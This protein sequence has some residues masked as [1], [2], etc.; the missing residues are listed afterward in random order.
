MHPGP[1]EDTG[2]WVVIGNAV[3]AAREVQVLGLKDAV[4]SAV[5]AAGIGSAVAFARNR[6]Y[7]HCVAGRSMAC[8]VWR[9]AR[10]C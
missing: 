9:E 6:V 4:G 8:E 5:E 1:V 10:G 7:T 2:H 3:Y